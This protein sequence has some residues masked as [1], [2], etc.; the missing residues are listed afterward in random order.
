MVASQDSAQ[1]RR[2]KSYKIPGYLYLENF[3]FEFLYSCLNNKPWYPIVSVLYCSVIVFGLNMKCF[4]I[5][6]TFIIIELTTCTKYF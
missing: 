2:G 1:E 6:M 4:L 5:N 3:L